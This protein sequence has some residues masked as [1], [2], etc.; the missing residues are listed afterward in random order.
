MLKV[1]FNMIIIFIFT[2]YLTLIFEFWLYTHIELNLS[3]FKYLLYT[4]AS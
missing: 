1:S 3:I 4:N 2:K